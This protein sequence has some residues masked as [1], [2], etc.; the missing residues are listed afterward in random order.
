M[1][2]DW[3]SYVIQPY[4]CK[5]FHGGITAQ[6]TAMVKGVRGFGVKLG[7]RFC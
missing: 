5:K 4:L 6:L 3:S 1:K 2:Q 7:L